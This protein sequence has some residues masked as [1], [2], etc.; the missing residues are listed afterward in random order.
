VTAFCGVVNLDG[1]PVDPSLLRTMMQALSSGGRAESSIFLKGAF[2]SA[3]LGNGCFAAS[4]GGTG[5]TAVACEARLDRRAWLSGELS[6]SLEPSDAEIL[7]AAYKRWGSGWHEHLHGALAAA[8]WDERQ[9]TLLLLRDR[10]GERGL[11]WSRTAQRLFFASEPILIVSS[12]EVGRRPHRLC[13]LAYLLGARPDPAWSFFENIHRVPEGCQLRICRGDDHLDRYWSS[14]QSPADSLD[15]P[16][17]ARELA[18]Q[19]GAAVARRLPDNGETGVLLSGGLDSCS[20]AAVAA[21]LLQKRRQRLHAFTWTSQTGDGIDETS[22]SRFLIASRPNVTEHGVAADG[23]WPLSRFPLAYA[24]PNSPET[25]VYPDLLLTTLEQA[26]AQGASVVLNGIGGDTM[27]GGLVPELALLANARISA[28]IRRWSKVGFRPRRVGLVRELRLAAR[29]RLPDWLTPE[30]AE[31]ARDTGF[32]RPALSRRTLCSPQRL[33][34]ALIDNSSNGSTLERYARLGHRLGIRIEAPWCDASLASLALRLPDC[35][36]AASP[37]AKEIL[38]SA[39]ASQLPVEIGSAETEKGERSN[40]KSIGLLNHA[41]AQVETLLGQFH[42]QDLGIADGAA[43]LR[44]YR[45]ERQAG[46]TIPRLWEVLTAEA[47]YRNQQA[48]C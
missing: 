44:N 20:V 24:D 3:S 19:L 32:D 42:L 17:A 39:M 5:S 13:L 11:Y 27:I 28:L 29:R 8:L 22:R 48:S 37:P 16:V 43:I 30:G 38:R 10:I 21:D 35:A 9:R 25:N 2:G 15:P 40:L 46:R 26:R 12:R 36:F 41:S 14:E 45:R 7:I 18:D 1:A 4:Q 6:P 23:L 47:W 31:M 33:R 34:A